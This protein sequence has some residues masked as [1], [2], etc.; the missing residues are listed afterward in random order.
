MSNTR[1][2]DS[3]CEINDIRSM[4]DFKSISFSNYKKTEVK[5]QLIENMKNSKLEPA[6]Y[7]AAELI[8]AG[9]F[10]DV[11]EIIL[12]FFGKYIHLGNPKMVVY[13]ERRFNIFRNIVSQGIVLNEYDLR[14]YNNIR[15]M[16]AEL[17]CIL[18]LSQRKYSI[19]PVKINRIEEF[20]I[21]FMTERLKA[22]SDK[23]IKP[24]FLS[25]DPKELFIPMNEFAYHISNES[26]N[27]LMAC[28]WIE[29]II[30][31][32]ILCK[33]KKSKAQKLKKEK[34]KIKPDK[35][36][37]LETQFDN[38]FNESSLFATHTLF[39]EIITKE[40]CMCEKRQTYNVETKYKRDIIWLLWDSLLHTCSNYNP[41]CNNILQSLCELFCIKYTTG[42]SKKRRY[43]LY[44]AV[45]LLTEAIPTNIEIIEESNKP[46][47]QSVV[48]NIDSIYK[49]IK[50]NEYSPNT[51]YLYSNL[52]EQR[53]N[54]ENT[55]KK[56]EIVNQ[57][58]AY[59]PIPVTPEKN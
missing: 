5:N 42:C 28:Y 59:P 14:N 21:S 23:Y 4:N 10:I 7:W 2:E 19:E 53:S 11:W 50:K 1:V 45:M 32:D 29:W 9:H 48:D 12:H 8:C 15:K 31:F 43:L 26:K 34:Q 16:F 57:F 38:Q 20:D 55:L 49:Q 30:E 17:I 25:K 54:I 27:T 22:S 13:L 37:G 51:D 41:F 33:T 36:E 58:T 39:D 24:V 3:S 44:F 52:G 40:P 6:S 47:L 18:C 56:M 46:I 35:M